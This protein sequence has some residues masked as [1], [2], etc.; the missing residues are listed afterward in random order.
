[1][2]RPRA[3]CCAR[4]LITTAGRAASL[5][6][7]AGCTAIRMDDGETADAIASA[8]PETPEVDPHPES[9]A[10]IL[11]TSG[12]T[13]APKGVM[14]RH[15]GVASLLS[16]L[17]RRFP[18]APG[19]RVL[20]GTSIAFDVHVAEVHHAL[21]SGATLVLAE[22][23]LAL[24]ELG[25]QTGIVQASM[26]PTAAGELLR[27]GALP[28][29][30]RR[31][32]LGGEPV[33]A[34]LC[35]ALYAA[36]VPQVH[37]F[38]GPTEDTTYSTHA[39]LPP[40]GRVTVGRQ[41]GGTRAYVLDAALRPVA[42]GV[43]GELYL[44]GD[45]TARG[46]LARPGMTAERFIPDPHGP[47]GARMYTTGDRARWL[48]DGQIDVLG[49]SD[50]QVKVRGYRIELGEVESALRAHPQ[51]A[52]AAAA[53]RGEASDRRLVAW[54]VPADGHRPEPAALAAFLAERLPEYMVPGAIGVVDAFPLTTSGKVDR[55]ALAEPERLDEAAAFAAPQTEDERA[56]AAVWAELLG[57]ED[58]GRDDG[59]FDRGGH[60]LLAMQLLARVRRELGADLSLRAVFEAPTLRAM[61]ARVGEMRAAGDDAEREIRP[62]PRGGGVP[63]SFAQ[64]RMW[65]LD[66][67]LPGSSVYAMPFRVHLDGALDVEALRLA[68]QD[69]VHR[70]EALRT[71]FA[72]EDGRPVQVVM[73]PAPLALPV[74]DLSTIP[75]DVAEREAEQR[76]EDEGRRPWDLA[77]GPLFRASLLRL[78]AERWT[79]L[80][81]MHH[82]VSD[83]W[84]VDV[85]FRELAV[86]YGARSRGDSPALP[87]LAVQ[88]P[89]YAAWQR[90]WL[91]GARLERQVAWWRGRLAGA[92]VLELPTDRP[93]PAT[94]SFRGDWVEFGTDRG[95]AD[96][97]D[98]LARAEGATLFHV[99]LAAFSVLLARWSG[100]DD[101]VV[102]SPVAGR[103]RPETEGMVGLFVNTL[104]LR[105]DLSGDPDFRAVV[106][107]V[108]AATVDAF[109]HQEVPFERL[110]DELRIE[111]SL[112]RH[113]LFQASFSVLAPAAPDP[114]LGGVRTRIEPAT[115]GT[116][117]FDLT[118][119]MQPSAQGL[120]GGLEY[121]ADLFDRPTAQRMADGLAMLI[122][123]LAAEP[124]RA[125]SRLPALLS[126]DERRRVLHE[127]SGTDAPVAARPIHH[128]VAE[129]A[130]RTPHAPALVMADRTITYGEME[131][132]ANRL[133]HHLV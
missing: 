77:A 38:Y 14:I 8:P 89:D 2:P 121:A 57:V 31:L 93:R 83:G 84:S 69:L 102:G 81:T 56:L 36:G 103:G 37:N 78:A 32:N 61:A 12:S 55:N 23:A 101:V 117:K 98:A 65:F 68:L 73:P 115:T 128:V 125:L 11:Y 64:E 44:A 67:L 59:F 25:P 107:R 116:A 6:L 85:L 130:A 18:L 20:G 1:C 3:S 122:R 33:P 133:A 66:R 95:T 27:A 105:T 16:W 124:D 43:P 127:W 91:S 112:S 52:N 46:Y 54:V 28:G 131:A 113:P 29:S 21:A 94:P 126:D 5:A 86:A 60:S 114:Q 9:L 90:R 10:H 99:L 15:G 129:Q 41:V 58:V 42:V 76:A 53:G 79:L 106:R 80:L 62:V 72:A 63:L 110:V 22:N 82:V 26:V 104:A 17:E 109:A 7:P 45:G 40:D 132:R 111:R 39:H 19:D 88:Y 96:A 50:F 70:H 97:V 71:V 87:P 118:V 13:G 74:T 51:V 30:V 49:R 4:A 123:A 24:A 47:P 120:A 48:A 92:P 34:D 100:Q 35:R 119:Q 108:R 75:A